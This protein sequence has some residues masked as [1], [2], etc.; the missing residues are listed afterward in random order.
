MA[1]DEQAL[2]SSRFVARP[3]QGKPAVANL[4]RTLVSKLLVLLFVFICVPIILYS[5]FRVADQDKRLL[6]HESVREQGRLI[7][8]SLRP[9]FARL[10]PSPLFDLDEEIRRFATDVTGIKVLY[11]PASKNAAEDFYFVATEPAVEPQTLNR[12]RETMIARGVLDSLTPSCA[13]GQPV[14]LRHRDSSGNGHILTSI[15]PITNVAGCW[16]VITTH[17]TSSLLGAAIDK[18]YWQS[19][20]VR[21]AGVIYFGMAVLTMG[22]FFGIWRG[23][24][25]FRDLARSISGGKAA[26]G[27]AQENRVPELNEVAEEF[28]RM[29]LSLQ[30]SAHSIRRAAEDNAH[31]FKTPLAIMRQALEP[32]RKMVPTENDRG[33]RAVDVMEQAIDRLDHL[34]ASSWRL[35]QTTAEIL[36]APSQEIVLSDLIDR[37]LSAYGDSFR[38]KSLKVQGRMTAG[39]VVKASEDLVETVLENVIDNAIEASPAGGTIRVSLQRRGT[40]ALLQVADEGP[41]V[42]DEDLERIFERYISLRDK[43]NGDR[44]ASEGDLQ[45]VDGE[46][47]DAAPHLGIGLWIVRRNLQAV[48]GSAWAENRLEGGLIVNMAFPLARKRR[49]G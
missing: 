12:V 5:Q 35:D 22:M 48:G 46:R 13:D 4:T 42:A 44:H 7:A 43:D 6:L 20:E 36:D 45:G 23:L 34:V 49:R 38:N 8:E 40:E 21:L 28:D 11:R 27:F 15:T 37:L 29:T 24:M 17:Q 2:G 39:L 33:A 41:G 1:L 16:A 14:A 30:D 10:E 26:G 25:Q 18:P 47:D 3:T 31:A 19:I 32:L 9:M